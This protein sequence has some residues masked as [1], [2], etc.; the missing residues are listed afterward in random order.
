[1]SRRKGRQ[2][3]SVLVMS[4]LFLPVLVAALGMVADLGV[5]LVARRAAYAAADM[6]A[7]AA[8][9]EVDLESLGQGTIVLNTQPAEAAAEEWVRSNLAAAFTVWPAGFQ[10]AIKVRVYNASP[11]D[12]AFHSGTAKVLD[13]PTV[14][15]TLQVPVSLPFHLGRT[16][17]VMLPAH[18][19]ASVV[20][21]P[22]GG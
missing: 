13:Y 14:C 17:V 8:V 1:M 11:S 19:D 10:P 9:Q 4:V 20:P 22:E 7:L 16:W 2:N 21:R 15:V 12:P 5:L 3:G 18:A 6:A